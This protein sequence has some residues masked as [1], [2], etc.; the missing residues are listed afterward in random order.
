LRRG[1][2][3]T[4]YHR[5]IQA[6]AP[7]ACYRSGQAVP[8]L[9]FERKVC[10]ATAEIEGI[11]LKAPKAIAADVIETTLRLT[12]IYQIRRPAARTP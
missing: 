12:A 3:L 6:L 11:Q 5:H 2:A 1:L 9:A 4:S 10:E 8:L 7:G